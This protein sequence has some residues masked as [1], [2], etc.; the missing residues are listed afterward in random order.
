MTI[1]NIERI[2][3]RISRIESMCVDIY[4]RIDKLQDMIDDHKENTEAHKAWK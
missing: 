4:K 1:Q 3:E 2:K